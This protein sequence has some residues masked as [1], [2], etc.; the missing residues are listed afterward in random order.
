MFPTSRLSP[1]HWR[2]ALLLSLLLVLVLLAATACGA[3]SATSTPAAVVVTSTLPLPT[4][5]T[6]VC[7][8][9]QT[10]V[11]VAG[12][13]ANPY[14]STPSLGGAVFPPGSIATGLEEGRAMA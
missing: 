13:T 8:A 12:G 1:H 4:A 2:V 7:L 5:E 9:H 10:P 11:P 14:P 3:Q 6:A